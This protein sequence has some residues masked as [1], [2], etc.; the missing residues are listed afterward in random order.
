M[1]ATLIYKL[2]ISFFYIVK[3]AV[4]VRLVH[5]RLSNILFI[6]MDVYKESIVISLAAN[7]SE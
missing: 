7:N 2:L 3:M 4:H 5:V 1:S 6:G